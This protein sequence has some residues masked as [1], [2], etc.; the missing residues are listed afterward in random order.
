[1]R[2][3]YFLPIENPSFFCYNHYSCADGIVRANAKDNFPALLCVKYINCVYRE[4]ELR[5][6]FII[7]MFDA[8]WT[9]QKIIRKQQINLRKSTIRQLNIDLVSMIKRCLI[10]NS[11]ILSCCNRKYLIP[12]TDADHELFYFVLVGYDDIKKEFTLHGQTSLDE[13]SCYR[14]GYDDFVESM[15]NNSNSHIN[16]ELYNY[17]ANASMKLDLP[18]I[19][20][21]L[22]DY[23][24]SSNS[25]QHYTADKLY[26]FRAIE[27]L[28]KKIEVD[29]ENLGPEVGNSYLHKF[30]MHKRFMKERVEYLAMQGII[31][32]KWIIDA[33]KV[34]QLA[35]TA[36]AIGE[37]CYQNHDFS[38][39][40][41]LASEMRSTIEIEQR[42]LPKVLLEILSELM[43]K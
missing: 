27:A 12:D 26:G 15:L 23:L 13:F 22:D 33:E 21:E 6:Q 37:K 43:K 3:S 38:N 34:F 4:G 32:K 5:H 11:Y 25:R 20:I 9:H 30:A 35:N 16:L 40:P 1:M 39:A 36:K 7:S 14:I 8:W 19:A 29:L 18:N 41:Q 31:D 2:E 24:Q 17:N 10:L 28:A 42:Y